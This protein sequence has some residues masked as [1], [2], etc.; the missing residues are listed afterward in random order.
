MPL[1]DRETIT[2]SVQY[3][4]DNFAQEDTLLREIRSD[5]ASRGRPINVGPD[6]GKIL[7]VLLT[8]IQARKVVE[9]GTLGAYSTLWMARALPEEGHLWT[10]END[11]AYA[12]L[13]GE[14]IARS[15]CAGKITILEGNAAD[16]LPTIESHGPFDAIFIDADKA[17]Y[18]AY[19]DWAETHIRSGGLIIGDNTF[20]FSA[21][22]SEELPEGV[23]A[24][25]RDA[26]RA[27]NAR[28]ADESK[29]TSILLPTIEG[30][31]VAVKL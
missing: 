17:S 24:K 31:T 16:T 19:L 4:R 21:V 27:F 6:E 8:M 25:T 22:Y 1:H 9:V 12:Q 3:I 11:P 28:L 5:L 26:M 14:S 30:M 29:Y 15:D 7:H 20:L 23:R 13:A 18:P 10:C 2:P